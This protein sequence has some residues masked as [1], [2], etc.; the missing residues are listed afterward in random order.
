M[1]RDLEHYDILDAQ[2]ERHGLYYHLLVPGLAEKRPSVLIGDRFLVQSMGLSRAIGMK[3]MSILFD[4]RPSD[5]DST[6]HFM[7]GL[8][9][10]GIPYDSSSTEFLCA[11]NIRRWTPHL[12]SI[13]FCSLEKRTFYRLPLVLA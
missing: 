11:V 5:C 6:G 8:S 2:L 10:S 4:R 3:A 9:N 1:E 7:A 12:H 13:S